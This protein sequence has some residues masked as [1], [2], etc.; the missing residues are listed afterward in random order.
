MP[1]CDQQPPGLLNASKA[2][3]AFLRGV[4]DGD[5]EPVGLTAVDFAGVAELTDQ[6]DDLPLGVT[7]AS[8]VA[9]AER[10]DI[11]DIATTDRRHFSVVRPTH[12]REFRL[13]PDQL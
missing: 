8:V 7:D 10:L 13:L 1:R 3:T 2:E 4:A 12:A 5:F 9:I 6:Y 11:V